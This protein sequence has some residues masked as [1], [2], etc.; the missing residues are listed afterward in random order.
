MA[1]E[2]RQAKVTVQIATEEAMR[3]LDRLDAETKAR[4][5]ALDDEEKRA[6]EDSNRRPE[7]ADDARSTDDKA[8]GPRSTSPS[9]GSDERDATTAGT[10]R[11]F[12]RE[13]FQRG[14]DFAEGPGAATAALT[15]ELLGAIPVAGPTIRGALSAAEFSARYGPAALQAVRP[16]IPDEAV[17]VFEKIV[18][19]ARSASR[20][21]DKLRSKLSAVDTTASDVQAMVVTQKVWGVSVDAA[22]LKETAKRMYAVNYALDR[23]RLAK[24]AISRELSGAAIG[25]LL[26]AAIRDAYSGGAR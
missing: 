4:K 10:V 26:G 22:A 6:R 13:V 16:L 20:F 14:R 11:R 24:D 18:E 5:K 2:L 17:P 15:R 12:G 21:S 25:D 7:K 19:G 23:Q 8:T 3:A 9:R 1:T